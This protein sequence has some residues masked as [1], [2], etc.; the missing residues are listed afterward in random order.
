MTGLVTFEGE[1]TKNVSEEG[2][3]G[4]QTVGDED[5]LGTVGV[6]VPK[7]LTVTGVYT[8]GLR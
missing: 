5:I 2:K 1:G 7:A 8:A 4:C 6:D 3:E